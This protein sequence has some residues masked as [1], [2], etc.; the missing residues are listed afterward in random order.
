MKTT[1][2][3]LLIFITICFASCEEKA[4]SKVKSANLEK[5]KERDLASSNF[6]IISFDKKIYDFGTIKEGKKV[7]GK[8]IIYNKGKANLIILD[9]KATCGCTIPI[10]PEKPI[11]PGESSE[12]NFV[13]NSTGRFGKQSKTITLKTNTE[14]GKEQLRLKGVVTK[15]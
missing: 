15:K 10:K 2:I 6:P 12:I 9:A 11:L 8:F 14:N 1:T 5:A 4:S 7:K 13:F 3:T